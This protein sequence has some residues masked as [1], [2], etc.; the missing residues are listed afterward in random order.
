MRIYIYTHYIYIHIYIYLYTHDTHVQVISDHIF[1]YQQY[2]MSW[3][4]GSRG[5]ELQQ[6]APAWGGDPRGGTRASVHGDFGRRETM[7]FED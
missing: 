4:L 3:W 2:P 5:G 1:R 6:A 7:I